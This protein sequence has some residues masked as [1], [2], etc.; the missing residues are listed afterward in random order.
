MAVEDAVEICQAGA[1]QGMR[2]S[3]VDRMRSLGACGQWPSNFEQEFH[4]LAKKVFGVNYELYKVKT[5]CKDNLRVT[6][7]VHLSVLLPHEIAHLLYTYNRDRF[8]QVFSVHKAHVFWLKTIDR[9]EV[10]FQQHPLRDQIIAAPDK[11]IFLP[12]SIFGDDGTMRKTRMMHTITWFSSLYSELPHLESRFPGYMVPGHMMIPDITE[13]HMQ[14][15][16]A[17]SFSVWLTGYFPSLDHKLEQF[18]E[19]SVRKRLAD[20]RARIA[21][22]YIAVYTNTIADDKWLHEHYRFEQHWSK[23]DIC[24]DCHAQDAPGPCN[25]IQSIPFPKR[26]HADYMSSEAARRSPLTTVPGFHL[27]SSRPETMHV[28]PLGALPDHVGASLVELC[29]EGAFGFQEIGDWQLRLGSQLKVAHIDFC[30]FAAAFNESHRIRSFTRAKFSMFV[31]STSWPY[32]KGKA[33]HCLVLCRWL[34]AKCAEF[35]EANPSPY[36]K[37]RASVLWA[38]VEFFQLAGHPADPDWYSEE[39]LKRLDVSTGLI[40]H[41]AKVLTSLNCAASRPRW[42]F[43][44]KLHQMWHINDNAQLSGRPVRSTWSWKEEEGMG[45]LSRIACAVHAARVSDRSLQRWILQFLNSVEDV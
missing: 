22:G 37:L 23:I 31:K 29:D 11:S 3:F 20:S 16:F 8:L 21:G 2:G 5:I 42:K 4:R 17:W 6:R 26:A 36:A 15:A 10:W 41:G 35:A 34:S 39:E 27:S 9:N 19:G 32:Y 33:H 43:R 1:K 7:D 14:E 18:P 24:K 38:W 12:F 40:L 28:G 13:P 45:K 30:G 44:P 25:Y